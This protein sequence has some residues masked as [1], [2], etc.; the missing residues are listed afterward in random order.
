MVIDGQGLQFF[1]IADIIG[2]MHG[3]LLLVCFNF[4]LADRRDGQAL[5]PLRF[6]NGFGLQDPL[7]NGRE[8]FFF[9]KKWVVMLQR[10]SSCFWFLKT[11]RQELCVIINAWLFQQMHVSPTEKRHLCL[12]YLLGRDNNTKLAKNPKMISYFGFVSVHSEN[13]KIPSTMNAEHILL[14]T[15]K[16]FRKSEDSKKDLKARRR[17]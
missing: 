4:A 16:Y 3:L 7:Y 13:S 8:L 11:Y 5:N 2:H 6:I 10:S 14:K 17:N 15:I 9:L 1:I 12:D